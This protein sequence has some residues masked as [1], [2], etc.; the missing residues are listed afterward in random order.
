M[1]KFFRFSALLV[2]GFVFMFSGFVKAVDPF[3]GAVKFI[4]YF[5]AF[6]LGLLVPLSMPLS[7]ILAAF[8]FLIGIHLV[9]QL[10]VRQLAWPTLVLAAFF[11]ILTLYIAIA[12]PV[13]DCGC[14]GD[15]LKLT[16]WETFI[17][18]LILLPLAIFIFWQ[19]KNV[20]Q[21]M[22]SWRQ[23]VL[24]TLFAIVILGVSWIGIEQVPMLDFRPYKVGTHLPTEMTVPADA[25]QPEYDTR[26]ILEKDGVRK[27]FG[28][29]DYP[30]TDTTWE[31]TIIGKWNFNRIGSIAPFQHP[32]S[33]ALAMERER[34]NRI[35]LFACVMLLVAGTSIFYRYKS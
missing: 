32:V 20:V 24:S 28:L 16:N 25:E 23:W 35:M 15:A 4:D 21:P 12:N 18:N 29:Q 1:I 27:E 33:A 7:I 11:T 3:G 19:R 5:N 8:E 34:S 6:G 30:Y 26:F 31:G 9:L 13:S 14:F 2:V 10:R 17:K 22:A